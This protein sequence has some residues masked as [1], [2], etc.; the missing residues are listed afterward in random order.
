MRLVRGGNDEINETNP[1]E[2]PKR[3]RKMPKYLHCRRTTAA[4]SA[5]VATSR[6][7]PHLLPPTS[8][9]RCGLLSVRTNRVYVINIFAK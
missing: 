3:E 2:S 6:S 7:A 8:P 1:K 9:P 5:N 4:K